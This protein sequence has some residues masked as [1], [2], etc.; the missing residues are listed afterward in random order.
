[1]CLFFR[2][3]VSLRDRSSLELER[4]PRPASRYSFSSA[5]LPFSVSTTP[6][7]SRRSSLAPGGGLTP[8]VSHLDMPRRDMYEALDAI[9]E[10]L[11]DMPHA[12]IGGLALMLLGSSRATKDIDIVV[13][14]GRGDEAAALLAAEGFFGTET[15]I[16][17]KR[18]VWFDASSNHRYNVDVMEPRSIGQVFEDGVPETRTVQ[19]HKV[20]DPAQLLNFKIA[21]WT[22]RMK[23]QST[24]KANHAKDIVFLAEYLAKKGIIATRG[25]VTHATDEF[26]MLFNASYPGSSKLFDRIGLVRTGASRKGSVDSRFFKQDDWF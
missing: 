21:S 24:K 11:P 23:S 19:G 9:A 13:P 26:L 12:I 2:R 7:S 14:D 16:N 10:A 6:S 3:H 5:K 17:G 4:G 1:M 25:D 15:T 22:D 18:R 8:S 20:L